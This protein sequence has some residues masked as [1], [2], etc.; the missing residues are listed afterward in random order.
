[1]VPGGFGIRG[2][3]GKIGALKFARDNMI[4]V[5]GLFLGL[6]GMVI[7][8]ARNVAGLAGASSSEFDH[9]SEFPVVATIADQADIISGGA[10]GGTTRLGLYEA[11]GAPGSLAAELYEAPF[12]HARHHHPSE[13]TTPTSTRT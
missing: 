9:E 10:L 11:A 5:L 7:E 4:P 8:Y 3:E 1:C 2:I 12:A 13:A 6:Q